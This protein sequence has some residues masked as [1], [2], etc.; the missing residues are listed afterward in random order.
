MAIHVDCH[1]HSQQA[2]YQLDSPAVRYQAISILKGNHYGKS[3]CLCVRLI[4]C[5]ARLLKRY[6]RKIYELGYVPICPKLSDSQYLQMENAD[7]KR[8]FQNIS[9]Q[10]LCRC[11]MLVVCGN[12]ISNSMSAEIGTAERRN[13]ICTT[14]EGLAKIKNQ[15]N[16]TGSDSN[17]IF[18]PAGDWFCKHSV[19]I[20]KRIL[21]RTPNPRHPAT[22]RI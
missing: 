13:I 2:G 22:H 11:R 12:E 15:M 7:E 10:K 21:G 17:V 14:L 20:S 5:R 19:W 8:E 9:R 6:C 18:F 4:R 16:M 1:R 3:F